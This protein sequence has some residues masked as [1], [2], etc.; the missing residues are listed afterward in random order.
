MGLDQYVHTLGNHM[1]A[2]Y[3]Q[4]IHKLTIDASFTCPNRDGTLG[5]GG[6]TFCNVTSFSAEAGQGKSVA[7][8]LAE[9]KARRGDAKRYMAYFQA[10]TSTYDEYQVLKRRY[11]E[12]LAVSDIV[13]LCVGTRPDCVPDSVLELL[14]QYREQGMELWLELGLQSAHDD[15]L[16][17]INRGHGFDAYRDTVA[18]ARAMGLQVCTH[19]IMG[20]PG[21]GPQHAFETLDRVLELGVDGLKLHPLHVVQNSTMAKQYAAGRLPLMDA[22]TYMDTAAEMIRRTPQSVVFHR[23]SAYARPPEL[24]APQWC[25]DKWLALNGILDRLKRDGGQGSAL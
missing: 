18:R 11:E 13:G 21:E 25:G 4:K 2:R 9:G 3:G 15:T 14:A 12:A 24:V 20:L 5:R 8:Q 1:K 7:L 22:D 17:R 10:Y 6:C 23:I 19:L 16:K